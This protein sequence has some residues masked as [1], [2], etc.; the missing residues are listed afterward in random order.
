MLRGWSAICFCPVNLLINLRGGPLTSHILL[1]LQSKNSWISLLHWSTTLIQLIP[2][3]SLVHCYITCNTNSLWIVLVY[4][5]WGIYTELLLVSW[6]IGWN[7]ILLCLLFAINVLISSILNTSP[8]LEDWR[9]G[10]WGLW[11]LWKDTSPVIQ[12]MVANPQDLISSKS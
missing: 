4:K 10:L 2:N 11:D 9:W 6:T 8:V 5:S 12:P 7:P 1:A 3:G